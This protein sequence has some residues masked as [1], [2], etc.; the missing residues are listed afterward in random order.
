MIGSPT[1]RIIIE[2]TEETTKDTE[3]TPITK[4]RTT[5]TEAIKIDQKYIISYKN[6]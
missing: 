2:S 3:K 6:E 5:V 1:R 4:L